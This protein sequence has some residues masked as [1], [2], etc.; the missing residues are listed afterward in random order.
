MHYLI[1][2]NI[3]GRNGPELSARA[4][5]EVFNPGPRPGPARRIKAR[6]RPEPGPARHI[7]A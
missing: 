4:R 7:K 5:P 1:N 6:A 2:M 3:R